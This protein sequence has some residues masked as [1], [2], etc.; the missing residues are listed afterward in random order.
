MGQP[1]ARRGHDHCRYNERDEHGANTARV[2]ESVSIRLKSS[3]PSTSNEF[4]DHN[5][6]RGDDRRHLPLRQERDRGRL[7][8]PS[9]SS[10]FQGGIHE[11]RYNPPGCRWPPRGLTLASELY[12]QDAE[13]L[14]RP[15]ATIYR[16]YCDEVPHSP[17]GTYRFYT[18]L[19]S[20]YDKA[21]DRADFQCK[22]FKDMSLSLTGATDTRLPWLSLEQPN[23]AFCFGAR[24]GTV[25]L[26]FWAGSSGNTLRI[27]DVDTKVKPRQIDLLDILQRLR[28]LE[29]GLEEDDPGRMYRNLYE[30]LIQDPEQDISPHYAMEMQIADLITV[31]SRSDWTDFSLP[32]NQVVA[33]FFSSTDSFI[34]TTFFHQLVLS[35]ELYLRIHSR[36]HSERAKQK[37]LP[38]LPPKIAWDLGVAQRWLENMS[39]N[40]PKKERKRTVV[41]FT[42]QS[43][44]R[45]VEALRDF[46]S[47]LK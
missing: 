24:P 13:D 43:K 23:M 7:R 44:L 45:Q 8:S 33:D 12:P 26:N 34:K 22:A 11:I 38:Q 25:T 30:H 9:R 10:S 18:M 17:R 19:G 2:R 46:A 3:A 31:L 21:T 41:S 39:L 32:V 5:R 28:H 29:G 1:G 42:L 4:K 36:D 6:Y 35:V 16:G 27:I 40:K 47:I 37:L 20:E 15:G 14:I